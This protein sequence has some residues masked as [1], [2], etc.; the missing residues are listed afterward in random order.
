MT[1]KKNRVTPI[2]NQFLFCLPG[3]TNFK[4]MNIHFIIVEPAVPGNVGSIARAMKTMGFH[5]LHL[6]NPCCHLCDE[7]RTLAYSSSDILE[8]AI[9]HDSLQSS[10]QNMD[11]II[12]T[13]AKTRKTNYDQYNCRD[14]IP[15]IENKKTSLNNVAIVFG[16][17]R[18]GLTKQESSFCDIFSTVPMAID[19][20]SLNLSQAVMIYAYELSSL[21]VKIR[22]KEIAMTEIS[23]FQSLK[24]KV[25]NFLE[26]INLGKDTLRF[27]RILER[28]SLL[29]DN[30][31]H[32]LHD[33]FNKMEEKHMPKE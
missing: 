24:L 15:I 17:E 6:V 7:A 3:K 12:G 30:D 25:T 29:T 2:R 1:N 5:H 9:V 14:L 26:N 23:Q 11:L 4:K 10:I 20:P 27:K 22:H 33:V 28:L 19:Y 16:R 18:S 13:T 8:K 31:I 32:L 21:N